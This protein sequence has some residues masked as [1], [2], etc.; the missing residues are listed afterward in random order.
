MAE[1]AVDLTCWPASAP[2]PGPNVALDEDDWTRWN[3]YGIGLFLQ[4]DLYG[5]AVRVRNVTQM[6]P[7]NPDGWMNV[8]RGRLQEGNLAAAPDKCWKKRWRLSPIWRALISFTRQRPARQQGRY[9]ER[10]RIFQTVA[11][12]YPHDRVVRDDL[13]RIFFLQRHY[14]D[15]L[16]EFNSDACHRSRRSR[17]QL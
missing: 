12:Q 7:A 2:Q 10:S 16:K 1:N 11:A 13:G 14:A 9:D 5:A 17:G 6:A 15:A 8:G 4:G 3:D